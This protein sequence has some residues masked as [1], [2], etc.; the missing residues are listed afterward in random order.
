MKE[1]AEPVREIAATESPENQREYQIIASVGRREHFRKGQTWIER[2]RYG[3][4]QFL[5]EPTDW[6]SDAPTD[7]ISGQV[8]NKGEKNDGKGRYI[9]STISSNNKIS[10]GY[11]HCTGLVVA[12]T[13]SG[14]RT[15]FFLTHQDAGCFVRK[16]EAIEFRAA[17]NTRLL[18][19]RSLSGKGTLSAVIFGGALEHPEPDAGRGQQDYERRVAD[20][21]AKAIQVL[22]GEV[23]N[24]LGIEAHVVETPNMRSF[25]EVRESEETDV[26]F[27]NDLRRLHVM[28]HD[29]K[30]RLGVKER[31]RS[32]QKIL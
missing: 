26:F 16:N 1:F 21:Y 30:K 25:F 9:F 17:L 4:R 7:E 32:S 13:G 8:H 11:Q 15:I 20:A 19:I 22:R 10:H 2:F 28:K 6:A 3:V 27:E 14:N 31:F 12:G 24:V 18:E 5:A 29:S 23:A